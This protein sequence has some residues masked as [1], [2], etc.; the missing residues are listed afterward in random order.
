MADETNF[1]RVR[2]FHRA[3][4]GVA[5]QAPTPPDAATLRLRQTLIGEE[6]EE[7]AAAFARALAARCDGGTVD[8]TPLA[9]ELADLLYVTY[10]GLVELGVDADLVFAEVHRANMDK[11]RGPKRADGKQLKPPDWQPA[12]VARVIQ[13]QR[14]NIEG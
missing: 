10:G 5:P 1:E 8:L 9:H 12:D 4:S 6:Y 7:T 2:A 13:G 3:V 11:V 14:E